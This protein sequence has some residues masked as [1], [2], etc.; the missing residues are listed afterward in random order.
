M[1]ALGQMCIVKPIEE[2]NEQFGFEIRRK[3]RMGHIISVGKSCPEVLKAGMEIHFRDGGHRIIG[4]NL[5][6][7]HKTILGYKE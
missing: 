7:S 3:I 1:E 6:M 2:M 4:D 5:I